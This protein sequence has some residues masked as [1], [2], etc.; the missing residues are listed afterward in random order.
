MPKE[1]KVLPEDFVE[2][3]DLNLNHYI[4]LEN[5]LGSG[6]KYMALAS[7]YYSSM[8]YPFIAVN[9]RTMLIRFDVWEL[10]QHSLIL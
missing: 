1:C 7:V 10:T 5:R 3:E 4:D 8:Q 9:L 6:F 2:Y